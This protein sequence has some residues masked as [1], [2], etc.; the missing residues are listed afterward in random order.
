M[1]SYLPYPSLAE[2]DARSATW[3]THLG[4]GRNP[5]DVTRYWYERR[6]RTGDPEADAGLPDGVNYA[7]VVRGR[8]EVLDG[9]LREDQMTA[10]EIAALVSLYPAYQVGVAYSVD[11]L[12]AY[13]GHL[14]RVVQAHT[15][16]S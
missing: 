13:N 7:V 16:Q 8:D 2:A 4:C 3:A 15:S 10:D 9:L 5:A 1:T 6:Q 11:D 14:Y 12:V